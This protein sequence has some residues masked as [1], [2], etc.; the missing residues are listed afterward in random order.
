M[1]AETGQ[2]QRDG[3]TLRASGVFD[4]AAVT[5]L[6]PQA[7]RLVAGARQLDLS[8]ITRLDSA[9]LAL[10]AETAARLP[11]GSA[12]TRTGTERP[13]TSATVLGAPPGLEELRA[14]YRLSPH[15]AFQ[16]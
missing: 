3:D 7:Q 2:L 14:A 10:L 13:N 12:A 5:A 4:R 1:A 15:L 16:D 6:W 9:G 8:A 11:S